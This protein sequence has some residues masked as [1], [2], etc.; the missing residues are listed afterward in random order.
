MLQYEIV[1]FWSDEDDLYI[2]YAPELPRCMAH[3][4]TYQDALKNIL[5]AM[6]FWIDTAKETGKPVPKPKVGQIVFDKYASMSGRLPQPE[7]SIS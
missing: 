1:I 5:D 7:R 3:G 4:D 2:A 6:E